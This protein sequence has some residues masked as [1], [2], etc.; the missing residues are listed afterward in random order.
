MILLSDITA[1]TTTNMNVTNKEVTLKSNGTNIYSVT[2]ATTLTSGIL[3]INNQNTI[4]TTNITFDGNNVNSTAPLILGK[5]SVINLKNKTTIQNSKIIAGETSKYGAG[6]N[7]GK[8]I[9]N[10]DGATISSN[11]I[12]GSSWTGG[13]GIYA[14]QSTINIYSG[15]ISNNIVTSTA[16]KTAEGGAIYSVQ[17]T[18]NLYGGIITENQA[19]VGAGVIIVGHSS[20]SYFYIM[21][22]E[23]KGNKA[24]VY[25][26]GV[27]VT[28]TS[29][30]AGQSILYLK[31]GSIIDNTAPS[32]KNTHVYNGGQIIDQIY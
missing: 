2:K 31:G 25:G 11:R 7:V 30:A 18:F 29:T 8:S 12:Q 20:P 3:D 28:K 26:G 6:I 1:T 13:G 27:L 23:I 21:D 14:S 4:T 5:N 15:S 24:S 17:S 32:G 10:I 9:L 19:H 22:G 16:A